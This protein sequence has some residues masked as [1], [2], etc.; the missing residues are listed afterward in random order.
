MKQVTFVITRKGEGSRSDDRIDVSTFEGETSLYR[1]TYRTPEL[2]NNKS[3][4]TTESRVIDYLED[5]LYGL[6]RD[7]APFEH[8]Q[9]S[10]CIHPSVIYHIADLYDEDMRRLIINMS[11]DALRF[12]VGNA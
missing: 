7:T 9:V 10:T 3:F 1:V 2:R 6:S 5:V 4:V 8:F 11:T 12:N